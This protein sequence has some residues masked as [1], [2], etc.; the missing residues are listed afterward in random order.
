MKKINSE[1]I[2][3]RAIQAVLMDIDIISSNI[4][5]MSFLDESKAD[6]TPIMVREYQKEIETLI[7]ISESKD[8]DWLEEFKIV[9]KD[10]REKYKFNLN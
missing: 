8:I 4:R 10:I 1:V 2:P 9:S 3:L 6:L 5:L 7:M